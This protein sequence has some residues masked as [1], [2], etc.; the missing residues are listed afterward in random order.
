M[1]GAS[2]TRSDGFAASRA[3]R[4]IIHIVEQQACRENDAAPKALMCSCPMCFARTPRES[5]KPTVWMP[6][7]M[8]RR[9][10]Q[11]PGRA[12]R[13]ARDSNRG[14]GRRH[15]LGR[16]E[17][18]RTAPPPKAKHMR[19]VRKT[20][21]STTRAIVPSP[22]SIAPT[23]VTRAPPRIAAHPSAPRHRPPRSASNPKPRAPLMQTSFAKSVRNNRSAIEKLST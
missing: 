7:S 11:L 20:L 15:L 2:V 10:G 23:L 8:V 3:G 19:T 1:R 14:V 9:N 6:M 12:V 4:A 21:S 13:P 22:K 17:S 18:P 5:R 16:R